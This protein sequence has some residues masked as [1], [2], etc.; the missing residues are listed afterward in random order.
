MRSVHT[1]AR[2]EQL[3]TEIRIMSTNQRQLDGHVFSL[4]RRIRAL[5]EQARATPPWAAYDM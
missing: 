2:L 4:E 1:E 3:Q 5:E